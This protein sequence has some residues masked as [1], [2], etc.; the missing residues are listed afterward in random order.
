MCAGQ[1]MLTVHTKLIK[2]SDRQKN[3]YPHPHQFLKNLAKNIF[4]RK[5]DKKESQQGG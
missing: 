3:I 1:L 2:C 4:K 5:N